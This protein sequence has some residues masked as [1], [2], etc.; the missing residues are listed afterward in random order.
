MSI[1]IPTFLSFPSAWNIFFH[2]LTFNLCVSFTLKWVSCRQHIV[3][4]CFIIQSATLCLLIGAFCPLT[5][6]WVSS[7]EG[8]YGRLPLENT[9]FCKSIDCVIGEVLWIERQIHIQSMCL[10]QCRQISFPSMMGGA[11]FN[12]PTS[13]FQ[14]MFLKKA[15]I[16]VKGMD[17]LQNWRSHCS[18]STIT[19]HRIHTIIPIYHK[20]FIISSAK[21]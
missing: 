4:F 2:P 7:S 9:A 14:E 12:Q 3:A 18:S 13:G 10:F 5:V 11:Q 15:L 8:C 20:H 17:F 1:A 21:S 6:K 16:I 19:C